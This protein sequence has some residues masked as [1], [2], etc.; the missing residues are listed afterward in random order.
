M[1][2]PT[3]TQDFEGGAAGW[4][5]KVQTLLEAV[6]VLSGEHELDTVLRRIV[7]G[8][9][10]IA[11]AK[12]AAL[13][14][15]NEAG[16]IESFI[17]HGMDDDTAA[18]IGRLPDGHGLLGEVIVA[19]G[20]IRLADLSADPRSGGFPPNHP[21]MRTFLG[22]PVGR[23]GR[24]YGNLYLTEKSDGG[25]FADQDEALVVAFAA[26]AVG[27]IESAQLVQAERARADAVADLATAT[28]RVAFKREM[29]G[30]ILNAQEAERARVSRDLHD[31]V[32]Q[33][34]T[35]V[36]LGLRLVESAL[37]SDEVALD[38][39]RRRTDD[40][41]ALVA[42]ALR[43]T[44]K[45]AFDLRP[46]ILDDVGLVPALERLAQDMT[47]RGDATV[48]FAAHGFGADRLPPEIETVVYRVVQEAL[49]NITRHAGAATA[50]I[51]VIVAEGRVRALV[52]DD[53]V[54]FETDAVP[55]RGHLGLKGM[56]ERADLVGG[57]VELSSTT[58]TGTST[59]TTVRLELPLV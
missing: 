46:T 53:G 2:P 15:Y 13:G 55:T 12:Y 45:L 7:A 4:P 49:T 40:V 14:I 26:F 51:T 35:S 18:R 56:A 52:E 22:V 21:P 8:A 33:A 1:L 28:E 25:P 43:R 41:R 58:G 19:S 17:H 10:T 27:A 6:L 38:D 29:L 44:R 48:S 47:A 39:A 59:G 11:E 54:G 57:T 32:G 36:L 20:P 34:L 42:D 23:G 3:T 37:A 31:D 30:E 5:L 50:S 16:A 24:R 9:A